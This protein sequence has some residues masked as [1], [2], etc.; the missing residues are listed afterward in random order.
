MS[1]L[2]PEIIKKTAKLAQLEISEADAQALTRDLDGIFDLFTALDRP[3]ISALAP[4]GHPL[5]GAQPLRKDEAVK[6]ELLASIEQNAP[7]AEN[8]FITVP[9]VIE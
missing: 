6:R 2:D 4:L 1:Q 5:G 9:K 3:D 7:L 8:D